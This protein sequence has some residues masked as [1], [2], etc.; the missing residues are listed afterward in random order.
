[1]KRILIFVAA[2]FLFSA[3]LA[4]QEYTAASYWNMEHDPLYT[5]LIDRQSK[6]ETLS[7]EEQKILADYKV[8]LSEYF[9]KLSDT[10]KSVYYKNR[11]V[12]TEKP[13]EIYKVKPQQGTDVYSGERSKY[14]Q[15][16]ITNGIF[17]AFYGAGTCAVLGVE[18]ENVIVGVTLLSAGASVLVPVFSIKDKYVS[19]N[20]LALST[21][22]KTIGAIQGFALGALAFGNNLENEGLAKFT[23]ALAIGSSITLGRIGYSLG[24]NKP[25]TEGRATLYTY[26]GLLMPFEGLALDAAFQVEDPR[27][28]GLTSLAFGVG[29]YLLA[30]KIASKN[31]FTRGDITATGTLAALNGLLGFSIFSDIMA[32]DEEAGT[33]Y[34]L[35]PAIGALGGSLAG[36]L[37]LKDARLTN[38]QGRNVALSTAGGSIIGLG[39][40]ALIGSENAAPYYISGYITGMTTYALMVGLYKKNNSS[41]LPQQDK[42][43]GWNF[44][45]MPQN[46]F[47]NKKIAVSAFA[48]PGKRIDFLPAFSASLRF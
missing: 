47:L 39:L 31:D 9:E 12:W 20:S 3:F 14:T 29:G 28:Y 19:Y 1:M 44:N 40:I 25:W 37:W 42:K 22:G 15:Y 5:N 26:Y 32:N 6:G 2:L 11:A 30:D 10:E 36:H 41:F 33:G 48:N 8:K 21:H 34:I 27:I 43:T 7:P 45:I 13:E 46:I 4:A 16:L 24:K 35:L 18:D 38:Q 23:G 17:G